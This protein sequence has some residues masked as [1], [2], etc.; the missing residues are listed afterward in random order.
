MGPARLRVGKHSHLLSELRV[1]LE[2]EGCQ[3]LLDAPNGAATR[4]A[5]HELY[6]MEPL[7]AALAGLGIYSNLEIRIH[8]AELPVLDGGASE[9]SLALLAL[10]LPEEPPRLKIC[11]HG[12]IHLTSSLYQFEPGAQPELNLSLG[13]SG[14]GSNTIA[15][16]GSRKGFLA[17]FAKPQHS[18]PST[19]LSSARS[20]GSNQTPSPLPQAADNH[21][22]Q[23]PSSHEASPRAQMLNLLAD[24]YL[25]GGPLQGRLRALNPQRGANQR[26]IQL[27]LEQGLVEP[28]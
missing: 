23:S 7:L 13:F 20:A 2:G 21:P 8:G 17:R 5:P 9:L 15:W 4:Q 28:A 12:E 27:A 14:V 26:L 18:Q 10:E 24:L 1:A 22:E 6:G 16:D 3:Y 25:T 11:R 19:A